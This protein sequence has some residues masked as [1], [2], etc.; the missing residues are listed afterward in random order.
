MGAV[1]SSEQ[2]PPYVRRSHVYKGGCSCEWCYKAERRM[3]Y[4][5]TKNDYD[6]SD[7][8]RQRAYTI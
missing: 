8:L 6:P 5:K 2:S 3:I 4:F 1:L 7:Y